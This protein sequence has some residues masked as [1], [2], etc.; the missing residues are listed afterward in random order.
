MIDFCPSFSVT[1][2]EALQSKCVRDKAWMLAVKVSGTP[3][4]KTKT[5]WRKSTIR[6][7]YNLHITVLEIPSRSNRLFIAR[8]SAY[9]WQAVVSSFV[10]CVSARAPACVLVASRLGQTKKRFIACNN[11]V[12]NSTRQPRQT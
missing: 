5:Y 8:A 12:P 6:Q 11:A 10:Y 3:H 4:H 2:W 9:S 1:W 7:K